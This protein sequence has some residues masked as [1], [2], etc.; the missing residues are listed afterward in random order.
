[1]EAALA[2]RAA[3][4]ALAASLTVKCQGAGVKL[5]EDCVPINFF[6]PKIQH[7]FI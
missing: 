5:P 6:A 1:M 7:K 3:R 4:E 2:D